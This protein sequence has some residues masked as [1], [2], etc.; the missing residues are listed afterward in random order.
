ME[1]SSTSA[2]DAAAYEN[3]IKTRLEVITAFVESLN[4]STVNLLL[5]E[6]PSAREAL[7][8]LTVKEAALR[9]F[10]RVAAVSNH[11]VRSR[12]WADIEKELDYLEFVMDLVGR[13]NVESPVNEA[14]QLSDELAH[15]T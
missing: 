14:L 1:A 5:A 4:T 15:I 13:A 8:E 11:E 10:I 6:K 9:W 2:H 7:Q 12:L 3:R